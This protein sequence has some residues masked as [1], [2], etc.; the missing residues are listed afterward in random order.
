MYYIV[1]QYAAIAR[2]SEM[3]P[4]EHGTTPSGQDP[5][6]NCPHRSWPPDQ[7]A[8]YFR[9]KEQ[10]FA[11]NCERLGMLYVTPEMWKKNTRDGPINYGKL[12]QIWFPSWMEYHG[13]S[14][15]RSAFVLPMFCLEWIPTWKQTPAMTLSGYLALRNK[16]CW[17]S[18]LSGLTAPSAPSAPRKHPEI[19]Q[20]LRSKV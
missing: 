15:L 9:R 5:T 10:R 17:L 12:L 7:S 2:K 4:L 8:L 6:G 1:L 3:I 18:G 13:T 19:C 14:N 20:N 11:V 16:S